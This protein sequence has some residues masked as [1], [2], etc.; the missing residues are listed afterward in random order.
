MMLLAVVAVSISV[1][2]EGTEIGI[3]AGA[4]IPMASLMT[5]TYSTSPIAGA[6]IYLSMPEYTIEGRVSIV[7]LQNHSELENFSAAM[8]PILLG[9]RE[10]SGSFFY[11]GGGAVHFVTERY[12]DPVY[13]EFDESSSLLGSYVTAG[14]RIPIASE[15][16]EIS[17]T[18]HLVDFVINKSWIGVTAGYMF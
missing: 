5:E 12:D 6:Q 11:G 16:V 3:H 10:S 13:G 7:F 8:I 17:A 1:L 15:D 9:L 4:L 14:A 18:Y 2:A